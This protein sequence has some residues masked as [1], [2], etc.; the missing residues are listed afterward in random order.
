MSLESESRQWD[1]SNFG[2]KSLKSLMKKNPWESTWELVKIPN[3]SQSTICQ[4]FEK[5]VEKVS[6]LDVW[7]QYAL[8]EKNKTDLF[9]KTGNYL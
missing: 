9:S 2:D 6:K 4:H 8:R 1:S 3:A 5:K 7:V